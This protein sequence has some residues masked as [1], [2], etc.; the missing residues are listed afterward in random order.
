MTFAQDFVCDVWFSCLFS[1]LKNW[2]GLYF[3]VDFLSSSRHI[4]V[5]V[6]CHSFAIVGLHFVCLLF[7]LVGGFDLFRFSFQ[8]LINFISFYVMNRTLHTARRIRLQAE[9]RKNGNWIKHHKHC[10]HC[11][12]CILTNRIGHRLVENRF[13][14][15]RQNQFGHPQFYQLYLLFIHQ[16]ETSTNTHALQHSTYVLNDS[17]DIQFNALVRLVIGNFSSFLSSNAIMALWHERQHKYSH[18]Q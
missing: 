16:S 3:V 9:K 13:C 10:V 6:I 18:V 14:F 15:H 7:F 17:N 2:N 1:S 8:K 5:V 11:R 4:F 12:L